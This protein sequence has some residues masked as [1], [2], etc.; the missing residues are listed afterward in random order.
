MYSYKTFV[1]L[2]FINVVCCLANLWFAWM[3]P[4]SLWIINLFVAGFNLWAC[5]GLFQILWDWRKDYES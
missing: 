3:V 5:I 1:I 4:N 2:F